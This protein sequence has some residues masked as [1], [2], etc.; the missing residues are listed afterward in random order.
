MN[1]SKEALR[2]RRGA[3]LALGMEPVWVLGFGWRWHVKFCGYSLNTHKLFQCQIW[4]RCNSPTPMAMSPRQTA[5]PRAQDSLLSMLIDFLGLAG[6]VFY[7]RKS[8]QIKIIP[9]KKRHW[10]NRT[11]S[12]HLTQSRS[13]TEFSLSYVLLMAESLPWVYSTG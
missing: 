1:Y 7:F 3:G 2:A 9:I 4:I 8:D 11:A 13:T 5:K 6:N 10:A 12:A